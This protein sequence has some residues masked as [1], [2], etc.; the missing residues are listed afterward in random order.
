MILKSFNQ[1]LFFLWKA[2]FSDKQDDYLCKSLTY[3]ITRLYQVHLASAGIKLWLSK[4]KDMFH[5]MSKFCNMSQTTLISS[6]EIS[7]WSK[8]IPFL[9]H[10]VPVYVI[11]L[12]YGLCIASSIYLGPWSQW[13]PSYNHRVSLWGTSPWRFCY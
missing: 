9:Q 5:G 6:Y 1:H 4:V 2:R 13:T 8:S 3:F 11:P 10:M 7:S 12:K